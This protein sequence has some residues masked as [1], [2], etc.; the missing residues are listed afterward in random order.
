MK[1]SKYLKIGFIILASSITLIGCIEN[2]VPYPRIQPNFLTIEAQHQSKV[3]DI[4]SVNRIV[5]LHLNEV[6]DIRNVNITSYSLTEG[7]YIVAPEITGGIDLSQPVNVT[8]KLYQEYNWVIKASQV[9]ERFFTISNQIGVASIDANARRVVAYVSGNTD[10]S[11]ITVSSIKLGSSNSK[12]SPNIEGMVVDFTSPLS[13]EV[14]DYGRTETWTIYVIKSQTEVITQGADA[15]TKVA[16]VYG[17]AEVGNNNGIEYRLASESVWTKVPSDW[18]THEGGNFTARIIHL[19]PNTSYVARAYSNNKYG[20]EV[21]F[22][23]GNIVQV[24]NSSFDQWWKDV[25]VWNPWAQD[26]VS[27]WDTGNKGA[28]TLGQSNS[29]PSDE[30]A[31]DSGLAAKLESKFVGLASTGKLAAG[32]LFT[33]VYYKTDG[34]NGILHFGREFNQRP[35]KLKGYWKYNC[36]TISHSNKSAEMKALIGQPDTCS[37]WIALADWEEPFE[38]RTNPSNRQLFDENDPHVIAYGRLDCGK[39]ISEYEPF[40]VDFI[41]RDTKRVPRYIVIVASASKYGDF[42]TGGDGSVLWVDNFE[43]EYDY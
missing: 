15:W 22:T 32:N 36:A 26:G 23:T 5:T 12:I 24:P 4:D 11:K 13:V 7:A 41:Y 18:V 28:T 16:W 3:A 38:I 33:G 19:E 21:E 34:T 9:I 10:L 30:T 20:E 17:S 29:V 14:T 27:Y 1:L 37:V 25:K 2:D 40:E 6:A 39:T 35:T 42:F 8:V 43:L 31:T